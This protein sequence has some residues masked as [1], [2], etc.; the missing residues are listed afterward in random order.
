MKNIEFTILNKNL[1]FN[2]DDMHGYGVGL[3]LNRNT[4]EAVE[5]IGNQIVSSVEKNSIS[6][7]SVALTGCKLAFTEVPAK[8]DIS[9]SFKINSIKNKILIG[10]T[11]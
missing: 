5:A 2:P 11:D 8:S 3:T 4:L 9:R 7:T 10:C 6:S 1:L